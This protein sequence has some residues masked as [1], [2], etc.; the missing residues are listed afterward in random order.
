M[1]A[2]NEHFGIRKRGTNKVSGFQT[3]QLGHADIHDDDIRI[4]LSSLF[5]RILSVN[6]FATH[7]VVRVAQDEGANAPANDFVVIND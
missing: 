3:V 2:E 6:R 7:F 1:L 4:Q 5:H